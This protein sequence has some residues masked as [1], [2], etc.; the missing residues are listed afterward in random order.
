MLGT[1]TLLFNDALGYS[2]PLELLYELEWNN[3]DNN[4]N[5]HYYYIIVCTL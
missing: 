4:N 1:Q 3:D 5:Y 2:V